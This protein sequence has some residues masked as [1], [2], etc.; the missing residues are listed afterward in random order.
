MRALLSLIAAGNV[1]ATRFEAQPAFVSE[2]IVSSGRA[3]S[4][5]GGEKC[6]PTRYYGLGV[7][8]R[9]CRSVPRRAAGRHTVVEIG[10]TTTPVTLPFTAS[11]CRAPFVPRAARVDLAFATDAAFCSGVSGVRG[12]AA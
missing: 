6:G 9:Q 2:R 8:P 1:L 12:C 10:L 5:A 11:F 4:R 7:T 3:A